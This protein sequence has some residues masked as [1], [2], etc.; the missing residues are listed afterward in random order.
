MEIGRYYRHPQSLE[1]DIFI[2]DKGEKIWI[3][4]VLQRNHNMVLGVVEGYE[5][6]DLKGFRLLD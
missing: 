6:E 4:W 1:V 3:A 2:L 5:E